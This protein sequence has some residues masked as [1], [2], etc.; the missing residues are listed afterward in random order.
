MKWLDSYPKEVK[1]FLVAS[2]INSA[3]SSLMW[4]LVSMYVFDELH[5][6][7]GDAGIAILV[8]SLGGIFGQVLGGTLY[9]R[10]GAKKLIVGSLAMNALGLLTLP[11]TSG[12]WV[13]FIIMMGFIGFFNVVSVPAIQAFVG[14]RFA[15]RRGELFNIIYVANNIGV[16]LGTG[17][18]GILADLSYQLS[19][20]MNGITSAVFAGF[21]WS[22]LSRVDREEREVHLS[23]SVKKRIEG[24]PARLLFRDTRLYLFVGLGSLF[25]WFGNSI[26]NTGVSPFIIEQGLPKS[27]Y[28]LLWTLNGVLI[29]AAQPLI[30]WLKRLYARHASAQ[31]TWSGGFYLAAYVVMLSTQNYT[32]MIFAMVLATLGEMLIAPAVPAFLSDHGGRGAPFYIGLVGGIGAAGRVMGP[33]IMGKLYDGG[34][35]PPTLW[36]ASGMAILC[37]VFFIL[38]SWMNRDRRDP[39]VFEVK[40]SGTGASSS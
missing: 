9:H 38:H 20:V 16:A 39:N 13:A 5:R 33:Y 11:F 26:W 12:H 10:I 24:T 4:P 40:T 37:I 30:S 2:L 22:Y 29:F 32:G 8:Q 31:M 34:G 1:V 35:L 14:F 19:F 23:K 15:D 3:G 28:G 21:F 6:S 7:M 17:L 36:L 27:M 18:S 25:L